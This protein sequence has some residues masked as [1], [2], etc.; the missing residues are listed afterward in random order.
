MKI[1]LSALALGLLLAT[2]S[3]F[4]ASADMPTKK[5]S[6]KKAVKHTKTKKSHKKASLDSTK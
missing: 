6:S 4:A 3:S 5:H 2:T 1:K